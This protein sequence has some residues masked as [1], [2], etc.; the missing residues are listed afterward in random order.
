MKRK[1]GGR[2]VGQPGSRAGI[3]ILSF[4][5][6]LL[7]FEEIRNSYGRSADETGRMHMGQEAIKAE[8]TKLFWVLL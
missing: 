2:R 5:I 1:A 3:K 6:D 7:V 4:F 8:A